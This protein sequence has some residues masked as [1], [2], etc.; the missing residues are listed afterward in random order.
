MKFDKSFQTI[1]KGDDRI[2]WQY[3]TGYLERPKDPLVELS[4]KQAKAMRKARHGEN[5]KKRKQ[6]DAMPTSEGGGNANS[7]GAGN[8]LSNTLEG[9]IP[10]A[11]QPTGQ[12]PMPTTQTQS[13]SSGTEQNTNP[14]KRA[15]SQDMAQKQVEAIIA[16]MLLQGENDIPGKV[17]CFQSLDEEARVDVQ[18]VLQ[19]YKATADPDTMY[20]HEAMREEDWHQFREAMAKEIED[21]MSNGNYVVIPRSQIPKGVSVLPAVWALKRKRDLRTR[22]VKKYKARLNI[23]G[24][25]MKKGVHYDLTYAPVASWGTIRLLLTLVGVHGWHTKQLDY[26]QAFPQA[27]VEKDLY[28]E[29]PKGIDIEGANPKEHVLLLKRNVYRQKQAGRV[30]YQHLKKRLEK[31]GFERSE[32]DECVFYKGNMIYVLYTDDSILAGPDEDEINK[33]IEEMKATGLDLTVEGD[34]QDFLGV[35]IDRKED[36]TIHLTQPHLIETIL[37]DLNLHRDNVSDRDVPA[38]SSKLISRHTA[39]PD[40]DRSFDYRSIIGKM[41][42]LEK[43]TRSDIAYAVHQCARFSSCPK[44]EHGEA[45]RWIA[46]YLKG[47]RD[48]GTIYRPDASRGLELYVDADF[49]G[50]WDSKEAPL[51]RDTAR[52][53]H[54]FILMYAGCPLLW[55]SSLQTEIALSST[56][57]EYTG[58]SYA[59]RDAI[60]VMELLKEMESRGLPIYRPMPKVKCQVFED[61]SGALEMANN[62][63]FRPRTKHI[64]VRLH[65]FRDYVERKEVTVHPIDTKDQLADY[66]TKAVG[67]DIL[68]KLRKLVMGW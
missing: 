67:I 5:A 13:G 22:L 15:K 31:A 54:G 44:K 32:I 52:S 49:A 19:V 12:E 55:K 11:L 24:S 57:S 16:E 28:M 40:F 21:Q 9:N 62:P 50:N 46:R 65:H 64:N 41:N 18:H 35:N 60:P 6:N 53:R 59:L 63:K 27:P 34:L 30:W 68:T 10:P 25:R 1:E 8:G 42:Y 66:L 4:K 51:D 7:E 20:L 23:D 14:A 26:V 38:A 2:G 39:S 56:E 58:L 61:N 36:G 37:E 17:L 3:Q 33:T 47:T 48:K 29:L 43:A 45:I